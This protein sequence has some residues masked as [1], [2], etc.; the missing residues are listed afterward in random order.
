MVRT[1]LTQ[2]EWKL[3]AELCTS[4]SF[5][6]RQ[7]YSPTALGASNF[8]HD[9]SPRAVREVWKLFNFDYNALLELYAAHGED[10]AIQAV[11]QT[12]REQPK[13]G[14][15]LQILEACVADL[16]AKVAEQFTPQ[17]VADK[18][19]TKP[20]KSRFLPKGTK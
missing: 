17:S 2:K 7:G 15:C 4:E 19:I 12:A 6:I 3:I 13:G 5:L 1:P 14:V 18:Y 20:R 8:V 10:V 16:D 11:Q 9:H